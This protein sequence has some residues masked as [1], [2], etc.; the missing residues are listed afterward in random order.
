MAASTKPASAAPGAG[1]HPY[2][3]RRLALAT[4]HEKARAIAP[5][6]RRDL[7]MQVVAPAGID[8]DQL[9]TFTGEIP[10]PGDMHAT[11]V[12]KARLGMRAAGLPLGLASEGSY[13][14][15]PLVPFVAAGTELCV[16]LDEERGIVI[17]ESL[18]EERT[19][20]DS[21]ITGDGRVDP[22]FLARV[23]FPE[24]GLIV[25]PCSPAG[26]GPGPVVKGVRSRAGLAEAVAA[27]RRAAS[28][29]RV[30]VQSD[31]RA[32]Q[33][34][35]R[36]RSIARLA[37]RLAERLAARCPA[38]RCPGFGVLETRTGLPCGVCGAPS[39]L[40]HHHVAGC[41][42]CAYR[43]RRPRPDGLTAADPG[44]CTVCNP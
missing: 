4:M 24:H 13:G 2:T 19:N 7:A 26:A 20:Y 37:E 28:D 25:R 21:T 16:L 17:A 34:P 27:C 1:D 32:H 38:C 43:E 23:G 30:L 44:R 35:T 12:A 10:R 14:P 41:P 29:G 15:H 8:T 40:V 11:A 9:G 5:A 36:M 31:M 22:K 6:L 33:N 18:L 39:T 42:A 3:G